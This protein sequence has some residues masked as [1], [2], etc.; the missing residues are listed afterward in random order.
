M[1]KNNTIEKDTDNKN[2]VSDDNEME[3]IGKYKKYLNNANKSELISKLYKNNLLKPYN[4]YTGIRK[5]ILNISY[6]GYKYIGVQEDIGGMSI[7][8][9]LKNALYSAGLFVDDILF[10]SCIEEFIKND[11]NSINLYIDNKIKNNIDFCGRTDKGVNASNMLVSLFVKSKYSLKQIYKNII[12]KQDGK[13]VNLFKQQKYVFNGKTFY[14]SIYEENEFEIKEYDRNEIPYDAVLNKFLPDEITVKSWAPIPL[15]F[16]ARHDCRER[17]YKYFITHNIKEFIY[18]VMTNGKREL[19][20]ISYNDF[21]QV[22]HNNFKQ[23][24]YKEDKKICL[25]EI[26]DEMRLQYEKAGK[27]LLNLDNFYYLSKHTNEKAN[28]NFKLNF[29]KFTFMRIYDNETTMEIPLAKNMDI[30]FSDLERYNIIMC[31]DIKSYSYLHNMVRKIAFWS[32]RYVD[33]GREDFRDVQCASAES[34]IFY[35]A[36]FDHKLNFISKQTYEKKIKE[37]KIA[38]GEVKREIQRFL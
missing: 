35:N 4:K 33:C 5:I 20:K 8:E 31:L 17:H 19:F 27:I 12:E 36:S 37:K 38:E 3:Y 24:N 29:L 14:K 28:Y 6:D 7:S 18:G 2:K 16:S 9:E 1:I 15:N 13:N 11:E 21:K 23:I 34:L 25:N 30:Y 32:K 10:S 26:I 22:N